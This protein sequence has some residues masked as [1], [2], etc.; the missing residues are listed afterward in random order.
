MRPMSPEEKQFALFR[1]L[2][3]L[4]TFPAQM[5]FYGTA[6]AAV[7][8]VPGAALPPALATLASGVGM[9]AL[10]SILERVARGEQVQ[11]DEIRASLERPL[12]ETQIAQ[13]LANHEFQRAL[14]H[15]F[16]QFDLVKYAVQKGQ[17]ETARLLTEQFSQYQGWM[18][19]LRDELG[20]V[21]GQ[22]DT[23]A[24]REQ[25][26]ILLNQLKMLAERLDQVLPARFPTDIRL[27][28]LFL[29][30]PSDVSEERNRLKTVV[31]ELNQPGGLAEQYGVQVQL[32]RWEQAVSGMGKVENVLLEQMPV[33][34]WDIFV[35]IL[36]TRFGSPT[37]NLDPQTG[38]P[39]DSGTEEEFTLAY[40]SWQARG[41]PHILFYRRTSSPASLDDIDLD[42]YSKVKTFLEKFKTGG[43]QPGL[44]TAYS[45]PDDFER[46]VRQDLI[47]LLPRLLQHQKHKTEA[48]PDEPDSLDVQLAYLDW[49]QRVHSRLELRGIRVQGQ[50]PTVSLDRVFVALKGE[51]TDPSETTQSRLLLEDDLREWEAR[52][53]WRNV[54]PAQRRALR[55]YVLAH[56]PY[57][58][59][60]LERDRPAVLAE[61]Q[62][63]RLN[64][65]EAFRRYRW[66]VILGDPGSG[67]TTLARWLALQLAR[68]LAKHEPRVRVPAPHVDPDATDAST[69]V[70]LGPARFPVLVRVADFAQARAERSDLSLIEY[71]GY[72]P[73]QG[74]KPT[75]GRQHPRQGE[76]LPPA[77]LN[78]LI[79][80]LLRRG[81]VVVIL[82][83]L[84]EIARETEHPGRGREEIVRAI[85][86][87]IRDAVSSPDGSNPL[88]ELEQP[89]RWQPPSPA[90]TG[91]NQVII[92]SRIA[93]YHAYPLNGRLAH[94][95][96]EP[97][98]RPAIARFCETWTLAVQQLTAPAETSPGEIET[99]AA[100]EA[101]SLTR[102]IY[103]P[104]RPGIAEMASNPLLLTIL[105][106]VHHNTQAQL[107]EQ[108]VRLYQ[109]AVENLVEVWRETG[110][111]EDEVIHILAPVAAHIHSQS[112]TGLIPEPELKQLVTKHFAHYHHLDPHQ[113]P[114]DLAGR[115]E[116][117]IHT[118]R[119][120]VGL[121]AAR[122]DY[123]Y[124][125]LHLTFQEY[126]AARYLV[127]D[128]ERA[129]ER[130]QDKISDPRWREP[131]LL[132]L[133]YV[134]MTEGPEA[135]ERMLQTLL[136][137]DDPLGDLL[138]RSALL[139]AQALP[140]F[141]HTPPRIVAHVSQRLLRAYANRE[142]IGRFEY[143]REQ[144]EQALTRL[145]RGDATFVFDSV[146]EEALR[147]TPAQQDETG[148]AAA[149]LIQRYAWFTPALTD[150]LLDALPFEN[151]HW[152]WAVTR[153]LQK[154]A[155]HYPDLLPAHRLPFRRLLQDQEVCAFLQSQPAWQRVLLFL[156]GGIN[157]EGQVDAQAV[158]RQPALADLWQDAWR[159]RLPP[160]ELVPRL[161]E[162]WRAP[163]TSPEQAAESILALVALGEDVRSFLR[164]DAASPSAVLQARLNLMRLLATQGEARDLHVVEQV[165]AAAI[166][167][168][169]QYPEFQPEALAA[170]RQI[171]NEESRADVLRALAARLPPESLG[172]AL[173]AA[174]QIQDEYWRADVL[175]ALAERLPPESLGEALA[176]ARQIQ[177]ERYRADVLRALCTPLGNHPDLWKPFWNQLRLDLLRSL[178]YRI[179]E[180]VLQH[181]QPVYPWELV[182]EAEQREPAL[183]RILHTARQ[184]NGFELEPAA[185]QAIQILLDADRVETACELV[186][187]ARAENVG[188]IPTAWLEHPN[189]ALRRLAILLRAQADRPTVDDLPALVALLAGDDD[190][191]RY[192]ASQVLLQS[193]QV[194]QIGRAFVEE[195]ARL[196][197]ATENDPQVGTVLDWA[198]ARLEHDDAQAHTIWLERLEQDRTARRIV[199]SLHDVTPE[200]WQVLFDFACRQTGAGEA[201]EA[202]LEGMQHLAEQGKIPT[203]SLG[204]F[205][206]WLKTHV[207]G[208]ST[209]LAIAALRVMEHLSPDLV[210]YL[211]EMMRRSP[212]KREAAGHAL[213]RVASRAASAPVVARWLSEQAQASAEADRALWCGAWLRLQALA[214]QVDLQSFPPDAVLEELSTIANHRDEVILDAVLYAGADDYPWSDYHERLLRVFNRVIGGKSVLHFLARFARDLAHPAWSWRR[215]LVAAAAVAA[216]RLPST[217]LRSAGNSRLERDL[218]KVVNDPNSFSVRRFALS[219][220]CH[221]PRVSVEV[222]GVLRS[223]M[224]DVERVQQ[225]ALQ[226]ILH[227]RQIEGDLATTLTTM[228][229][230]PSA[231]VAYASARLL[232][233]LGRS[234]KTTEQQRQ[235]ILVGLAQAIRDPRSNRAVYLWTENREEMRYIGQLDQL[236]HQLYALGR[237]PDV[238]VMRYIGQL[239]QL[240]HRALVAIAEGGRA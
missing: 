215:I 124:G 202:L 17:V 133:G 225:D 105:A 194:S 27:L 176:A 200:C 205:Q 142:G 56:A 75:F 163:Q 236:F 219:A 190:R 95:T 237:A 58:P 165:M 32:L 5:M 61:R 63:E 112:S 80:T 103:D 74:D 164:E 65:A 12:E 158:Y 204:A 178:P 222:I 139:I 193:R 140:E 173:A 143:L 98:S 115:I 114:P 110:L 108:R 29:A 182:R 126:L 145:R 8:L 160:N 2:Q 71:L 235:T 174:R 30:S 15:L 10:A 81:Q 55:S 117:F 93:G 24:T 104:N 197:Q 44:F 50:L 4:T 53:E 198:L 18:D 21:R 209:D 6:L 218:L 130:I 152:D 90:E 43:A 220:L 189:P 51:R 239:D 234:D 120:Q 62:V 226:N 20:I 227:V 155:L 214:T 216:E 196:A 231:A 36:W 141:I 7:A 123:L 101:A 223:A 14:A 85:E 228:L 59:S 161:I 13:R 230:A 107:P 212:A 67:K 1:V 180:N 111:K 171:Q 184:R 33:E 187:L 186:C 73:W 45:T 49:L 119:E 167:I 84:D 125:F 122:G 183:R 42:Q 39:F 57:M 31:D 121:L 210:P 40:R 217:F 127:R 146:L 238:S 151:E 191:S 138:P 54:S 137:A 92:T 154:I 233:A 211:Q 16:R 232:E 89:W 66:L 46:R 169:M 68:A 69:F 166:P 34:Q 22:L 221:L 100:Q 47:K 156:C 132:A 148:L 86:T 109:I 19:E 157:A 94:F 11:D 149:F 207:E 76:P 144:I 82:D 96:I 37:G 79:R 150:A 83:G 3:A 199:S 72:H 91:G 128:R 77:E 129:L 172:E 38:L 113:L 213:A 48:P 25:S 35:G 78:R 177:D 60:L 168:A 240:F 201:R 28:R 52:P 181:L 131:I 192:R 26:E 208:E 134:V 9:N 116:Q 175:R 159:R 147:Q 88:A 87:F 106:L 64:L 203:E 179:A 224:R 170:A 185:Q 229:Y 153:A 135:R 99:R 188:A 118:V 136:D 102:A 97:M 206:A 195:L 41:K 162:R 23:L 70:D